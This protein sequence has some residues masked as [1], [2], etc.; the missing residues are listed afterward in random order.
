MSL[1]FL[2]GRS[3]SNGLFEKAK[4]C[5]LTSTTA[6][7]EPHARKVRVATC[8]QDGSHLWFVLPRES[9]VANDIARDPHVTLSVMNA[10]T[11]RLVHVAGKASVLGSRHDPVYLDPDFRQEET[12][13]VRGETLDITLLRVDVD[14]NEVPAEADA[15]GHAIPPRP[16]YGIFRVF[17]GD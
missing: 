4:S 14:E 7:G 5:V 9:S 17:G 15:A 8:S 13:D 10:N 12:L 11:M 16:A 1:S 2:F 6:R 3:P